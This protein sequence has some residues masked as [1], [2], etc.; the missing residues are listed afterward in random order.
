MI[1]GNIGGGSTDVEVRRMFEQAHIAVGVVRVPHEKASGQTKASAYVELSLQAEDPEIAADFVAHRLS[2][3][4]LGGRPITIEPKFGESEAGGAPA[5]GQKGMQAPGCGGKGGA[6]GAIGGKGKCVPPPRRPPLVGAPGGKCVPPPSLFAAAQAAAAGKGPKGPLRPL[7][8]VGAAAGGKGPAPFYAKGGVPPMESKFVTNRKTQICVYW[9]EG[10]CTRGVHCSFAHG[11]E[12]IANEYRT[13]RV[14]MEDLRAKR[15]DPL[16]APGAGAPAPTNDPRRSRSKS[17]VVRTRPPKVV[18]FTKKDTLPAVHELETRVVDAAD[19]DAAKPKRKI[20]KPTEPTLVDVDAEADSS[21][22][23]PDAAVPLGQFHLGE[24]GMQQLENTYGLGLQMLKAM[25]W[26]A[27][28][29]LGKDLEGSLEPVWVSILSQL[30]LRYGTKDRRCLG[31]AP[32]KKFRDSDASSSVL[33]ASSAASSTKKRRKCSRSGSRSSRSS[34]S[35]RPTRVKRKRRRRSRS[36]VSRKSSSSSSSS[37]S[38]STRSRKRR[39][40]SRSRKFKRRVS[41]PANTS[42]GQ[43][44]PKAA[45]PPVEAGAAVLASK[46]VHEPPEIAQAKKQVLAKLTV[47]KNI[48]EKEQR[49][50]E[51]RQLLR[52]WHPDKNPE[53]IEMATAVFQ[54][55]QKGKSLLNLK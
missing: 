35:L 5:T 39:R 4:E 14:S 18:G 44:P 48:V 26:S 28:A 31:M 12:E 24:D 15:P 49:Q 40:R 32:P 52:E 17:R 54:F 29:G 36:S 11:E 16:G 23:K 30:G 9:R 25:G 50:K 20:R 2:G 51:F 13:R 10:R 47:M 7:Q 27:G 19:A 46:P 55:L 45:E 1:L 22:A 41:A 37:R 53:R 42:A 43:P 8:P 6:L 38:S 21:D 34:R 33:S 3:A